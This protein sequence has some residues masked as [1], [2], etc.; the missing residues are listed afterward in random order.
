LRCADR[1]EGVPEN[2]NPPRRA[3]TLEPVTGIEPAT[4]SLQEKR[5]TV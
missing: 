2:P 4:S 5:S 3:E 1:G